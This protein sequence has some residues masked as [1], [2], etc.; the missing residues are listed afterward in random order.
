[1]KLSH[2]LRLSNRFLRDKHYSEQAP[3]GDDSVPAGIREQEAKIVQSMR[4]PL[5][6]LSTGLAPWPDA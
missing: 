3:I 4:F 5:G 1:M 6:I 2:G